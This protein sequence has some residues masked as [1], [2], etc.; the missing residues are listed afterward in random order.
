MMTLSMPKL[1]Q[2]VA[3]V[4]LPLLVFAIFWQS[5]ADLAA[6]WALW[7]QAYSHGFLVVGVAGY[8][9]WE[10]LPERRAQ[11]SF[12]PL[13]GGGVALL[14]I[15]AWVF[16]ARAEVESAAQLAMLFVIAGL[17]LA[18]THI[19][20]DWTLL[21]PLGLVAMAIPIWDQLVDP[22]RMLAAVVVQ[23]LL[24]S[25]SIPA[26]LDEYVIE[27]A[28]GTFVIAGG[29]SGLAFLLTSLSL[30]GIYSYFWQMLTTNRLARKDNC[31]K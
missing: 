22:L 11:I 6:V 16:L 14:G 17:F 7:D 3:V 20:P 26:I 1:D 24:D 10:A 31:Q 27:I 23:N 8:M 30:G 18:Y 15:A 29:C 28:Y 4:L 12:W 5:S 19:K 2:I 25:I 9:L 13:L 21:F